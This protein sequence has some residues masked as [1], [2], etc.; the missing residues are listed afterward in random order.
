MLDILHPKEWNALSPQ[1]SKQYVVTLFPWG[2]A[3]GILELLINP[4]SM[5]F[6]CLSLTPLSKPVGMLPSR[7]MGRQVSSRELECML[8]EFYGERKQ[9]LILKHEVLS[10]KHNVCLLGEFLLMLQAIALIKTLIKLQRTK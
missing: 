6:L 1:G 8:T 2:W 3:R 10:N 9:S 5:L 4:R 7:S